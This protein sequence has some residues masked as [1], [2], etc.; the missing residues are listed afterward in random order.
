MD[1]KRLFEIGKVLYQSNLP[2]RVR[3]FNVLASLGCIISLCNGVF[4][5]LNNG[6]KRILIINAGIAVLSLM[7]L[8]Y[9]YY[10]KK[11]QRCYFITIVVI[12]MILF[13]FMFFKS[14]G[15]KGGMPSFY[16]FGVLFTVFMLEGWLMFFSVLLELVIYIATMGIAYYYP[17]CVSWF[18][19]EKEIVADVLTGVVVA[20]V[21]LGAA[22]YFHF[23]IYRKQQIFLTQAREEAMEANQAKS[24]FLANMSHEIRTPINVMLGMNEMILRESA[25]KEIVQYA[26]SVEKAGRYLLSLINNILDITRIESGKLDI[27]EEKFELRQLIQEIWMIGT[28]QAEAKKIDFVIEA[29]EELPKYLTG[30]VLHTKQVILNL[31]SNAVKYTEEGRVTLEINASGDQIIFSVKDTGIGIRKE[32][33]DT[34]F[35]MFTRVDMKRH[36]NIEGSGLGLTIAKELCEQMGGQIYAESIYGKGS[37]FTVCL[38]LKSTGEEKI[39]KWNFE[40]SKKVSEDRKRFFAPKAK[41][42]IVDDSQQN[43]Q[44]LASLL[45]RTSMQLD[46]AGSGLE[47][48]EKVRSKKYHL[49]FLDYMMPEMDGME[50]FHKLREEENGQEVPIIAIT[51]DVSTGIRQKFLSE[52]FADYLSKPVMWDRLEEILLQFIPANLISREKDAREEWK[53]EEKQILELKQKMKQWDIELSEGLRLLSGSISQYRRLAEL[54]VEYY[55]PNKEQLIQSFERLQQ[56][57]NE[58]KNMTGLLHTL[59]SN[60]RA[61]GAIELYEL[62]FTMEKKGKLQDVN[63]INKAIPLLFFEWERV[64]QGICFFIKYTEP[65]LLKNSAKDSPKQVEEDCFNEGFEKKYKEAKKELLCAIGRYQGKYAE[66][67]IEILLSLEKDADQ[68]KQLEKIQKSVRNLEFDE[69]EQLMEEWEKGYD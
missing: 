35:D 15:Y 60:A 33:M 27:T 68:R 59:K 51:A 57:Q 4:S 23:R 6:D 64:V 8:F 13:P 2:F 50:T 11:Y 29:E 26:E 3:L 24:I 43:L 31:I 10:R 67:Q 22:M 7:L 46:K 44:V 5:Y 52:G 39:G 1:R 17:I 65:F 37:R 61:I 38:P 16:I 69:A 42:L 41:V 32:D 28:K 9:A 47:C 12:F 58:I 40:E 19:S 25:S 45:Q 49:I 55:V 18:H 66:E 53:I 20:S 21:S 14:G 36:R 34:L 48:I 63:Y 56:T 54:F 62:S 30:D